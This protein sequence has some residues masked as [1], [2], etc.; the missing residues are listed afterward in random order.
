M[1]VTLNDANFE[2]EVLRSEIPVL[3][4]FWAQWCMP[5]KMIASMIDEAAKEYEGKV[6]VCKLNVDEVQALASKYDIMSIPTLII[7]KN[8]EVV[9]KMVGAIPKA[10]LFSHMEKHL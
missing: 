3:V 8:G 2:Q 1:E 9:D 10:D 7:F 4:D 5:C 6:K